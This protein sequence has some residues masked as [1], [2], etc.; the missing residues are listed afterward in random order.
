MSLFVLS[1]E[2]SNAQHN[3]DY[4]PD[5]N[6]D[7]FYGSSD[8]VALLS[9]FGTS[10]VNENELQYELFDLGPGGGFIFFV[11]TADVFDG[12]TYLEAAPATIG[13]FMWGDW[14]CYVPGADFQDIGFGYQNTIDLVSAFD[15]CHTH[16]AMA[17][18][19]YSI[20]GYDDWFLPS[21]EELH[22]MWQN[23]HGNGIG[24]F[25]E[26]LYG[27]SSD[28]VGGENHS[29]WYVRFSDGAKLG[30]GRSTITVRPIRQF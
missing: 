25:G 24:F 22:L 21:L 16:A 1:Y 11:D 7:G 3:P 2:F 23:L 5:W 4:D 20:N 30:W 26:D 6:G 12:W 29:A 13:A 28:A 8:L 19:N 18:W 15:S 9:L 27:S 17:A 14:G 10:Q